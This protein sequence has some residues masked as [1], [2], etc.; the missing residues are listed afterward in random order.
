MRKKLRVY[1]DTSV[2]NF[3]YADE[4]PD[5][6]DATVEF[7]S[8]IEEEV[9]IAHISDVVLEEIN[10]APE[11]TKLKLLGLV[12]RYNLV[13]LKTTPEVRNLAS[14][15]VKHSIIPEDFFADAL[16]IAIAVLNDID[17]VVSWNLEHIVKVKTRRGVNGI[18]KIEGYREIEIG[19]PEEVI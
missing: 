5:K 16:H 7:F 3:Y 19:T 2:L 17:I 15:Y 9:Y 14:K 4:T 12:S 10:K 13:E 18:N 6:R 11:Q 1:L 8:E